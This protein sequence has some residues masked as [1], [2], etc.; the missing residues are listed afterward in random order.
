MKNNKFTKTLSI[1]L[2]LTVFS[3]PN[4]VPAEL[5][6]ADVERIGARIFHYVDHTTQPTK[7]VVFSI[8]DGIRDVH[9]F[10]WEFLTGL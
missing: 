7:Q 6:E 9:S 8:A 2:L 5:V 4:V 10:A 1:S 3:L